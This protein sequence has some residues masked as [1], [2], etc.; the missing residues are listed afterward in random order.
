MHNSYLLIFLLPGSVY[1]KT[2]ARLYT[3]K[4]VVLILGN[5]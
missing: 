5:G 3:I 2:T 1:Y 4:G